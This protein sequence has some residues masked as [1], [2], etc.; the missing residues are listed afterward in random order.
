MIVRSAID[1]DV[2]DIVAMGRA[3]YDATHYAAFSP[4]CPAS[5]RALIDVMRGGVLLVAQD[6]GELLG[7]VGLIVA[8][9]PFNAA[10]K[11]AHEIMWWVNPDAQRSGVGRALLEAVEPACREA[12][13]KLVQMTHLANSPPQA[14]ALYERMG[15]TLCESSYSKV[16]D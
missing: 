16:L 3:F 7:M 1:E 11:S 8:P 13:A 6:N 15:F 10:V 14:G 4:Y 12:G 5:A 2:A 9:F